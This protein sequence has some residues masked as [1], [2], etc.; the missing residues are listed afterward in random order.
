MPTMFRPFH[1]NEKLGLVKFGK[2]S[3]DGRKAWANASKRKA[4]AYERMEPTARRMDGYVAL[5]Q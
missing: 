2:L 5:G 4:M 3:I 1:A